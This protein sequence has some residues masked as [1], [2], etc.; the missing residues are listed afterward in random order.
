VTARKANTSE[1][2]EAQ[3]LAVRKLSSSAIN[4]KEMAKLGLDVLM[5]EQVVKLSPSF[6]KVPAIQ[7]K[8]LDQKGKYTGFYRL[9]YL[10][11]APG[12]KGALLKKPQRYA[13]APNTLNGV[14]L[15]PGTDWP[16]IAS[17]AERVVAITEGEFKALSA[18]MH[19]IP[20]IGLGGVDV[21]QAK[22]RGF[23]LLP[24]LKEFKWQ[25]REVVLVYD[26]D[27]AS[28]EDVQRAL[29]RFCEKLSFELGAKPSVA[30]LEPLADGE[31]LGLDDL[32]AKRGAKYAKD[33]L[34]QSQPYTTAQALMDMNERFIY[35]KHPGL[36]VDTKDDD[37][38]IP[39]EA[40]RSHVFANAYYHKQNSQGNLVRAPLAKDWIE[41]P[42]RRELRRL[43]FA[44]GEEAVTHD[45][46]LNLWKGWPLSPARGNV[47]PW[48]ELL[49]YLFHG[50]EPEARR[51]FERWCAYPLQHPGTKMFT[52]SIVTGRVHG[53]GK[54]L[55]GYSLMQI[56]GSEYSVEIGPKTFLEDDN[57]WAQNKLFVLGNEVTGSDKRQDADRVKN[58]ITQSRMR[59]NIKYVPKFEV[60]D[61]VN[62]YF[63][64]NH[65]DAFYLEDTD[66]RFFVH[67][68]KQ[69]KPMHKDFYAE[70]VRWVRSD[71]GK[72]ALFHYLLNVP[73][74]DFDPAAPALDTAAKRLMSAVGRTDL[75]AFVR[76]ELGTDFGTYPHVFRAEDVAR[77]F[78]ERS[79]TRIGSQIAARELAR[80]G[81]FR[82]NDGTPVRFGEKLH[83]LWTFDIKLRTVVGKEDRS[84]TLKEFAKVLE[85]KAKY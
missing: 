23:D 15:A 28:N 34:N 81:A 18:C 62:Y 19:G 58:L 64:S 42:F 76:D 12:L 24:A 69:T 44:P 41:W 32:I 68:V 10:K 35:V 31:K 27:L 6:A 80:A 20:T 45:N 63:T 33:V 72:A 37:L 51:W 52:A 13:Q 1:F 59:V 22:R 60:D 48:H 67:D 30:F 82:V 4:A 8:Y 14:Y 75:A 16:A 7:I 61:R 47:R 2:A 40:F 5:P 49:D 85:N 71:E 83:R 38:Q 54:S 39:I 11:E 26:S 21:W 77:W 70:Y 9:R 65:A 74:G 73:L 78:E 57:S 84:E 53:T 50:A 3:E 55:V 46:C 79:H 43:A 17:D 36:I 66:R 56:Y 29:V 25:G